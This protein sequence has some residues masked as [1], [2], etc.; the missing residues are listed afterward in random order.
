MV[1]D[2]DIIDNTLYI[3][4]DQPLYEGTSDLTGYIIGYKLTS[5]SSYTDI[6]IDDPNITNYSI[7]DGNNLDIR[8]AATNSSGNGLFTYGSS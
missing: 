2:F 8:V 7:F 6:S 4:W 5:E 1:A 3:T